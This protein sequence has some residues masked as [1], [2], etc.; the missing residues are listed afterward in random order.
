MTDH[1]DV[2]E[3][4]IGGRG[5]DRHQLD[6][7]DPVVIIA[8]GIVTEAVYKPREGVMVRTTKV[9]LASLDVADG[10]LANTIAEHLADLEPPEQPKLGDE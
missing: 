9:Q 10:A 2:A 1:F 4:T 5:I 7:G 8:R 6:I 3:I